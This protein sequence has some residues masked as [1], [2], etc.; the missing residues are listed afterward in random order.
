M[1]TARKG[2]VLKS[3]HESV[4]VPFFRTSQLAEVAAIFS[5]T[6][7]Y[8]PC[9]CATRLRHAPTEKR[10]IAEKARGNL[11]VAP[12][13]AK[14]FDQLFEL[15][16]HLMDE[17]LALIQ[18]NLRLAAREPIAGSANRK[19]LFIQ[20]AADLPNDQYVLALV[21]AAIS[22]PLNRL[23]LRKFLFPVTQNVRFDSAQ[24]ADLADREVPLTR[25]R[26]QFAVIAWFQ[27]MPLPGPSVSGPAG[28]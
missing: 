18:I 28:R 25:D 21:V 1:D 2:S 23:E 5:L 27:H 9:K 14:Y 20:K 11:S 10:M 13:A 16:P 6:T 8:T 7:L 4:H 26:R 24:I 15:E 17:L 12:L 3:V 19:A 22:A